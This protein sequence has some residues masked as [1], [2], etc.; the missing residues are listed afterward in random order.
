MELL[1]SVKTDEKYMGRL[2]EFHVRE[3]IPV[4]WQ[5]TPIE[6]LIMAQNFGWPIHASGQPE[7]LISTCIEFRYALPIPRMAAYVVRRPSG[8]LIGS[9]F[10]VGFVLS[11]G[12][13]YIA[14]IGHND[15]GMAK[16]DQQAGRV[17]DALVNQGW[18]REVATEFV[19]NRAEKY[20][21]TDELD[22]LEREYNRLYSLFRKIVVAP[23]FVSLYDNKFYLPQWYENLRSH[24]KPM[25]SYRVPDEVVR[26]LI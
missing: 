8:L 24:P 10:T 12:I 13:S 25:E 14:M 22:A 20:H 18:G 19:R 6:A 26:K 1:P 5:N 21:M 4:E 23:L 16:V 11:K 3:D 15:C 7:M 9:E 17:V 2:I